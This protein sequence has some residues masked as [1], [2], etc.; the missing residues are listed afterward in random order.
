MRTLRALCL[1]G[2]SG[3]SRVLT[4]WFLLVLL[5]ALI[6]GALIHATP[7]DSA[8]RATLGAGLPAKIKSRKNIARWDQIDAVLNQQVLPRARLSPVAGPAAGL[9]SQ[10]GSADSGQPAA[11][12]ILFADLFEIPPGDFFPLTNSVLK[13]VPDGSLDGI[14]VFDKSGQLLGTFAGRSRYE[15]SGDLYK[16]RS[17]VLY[18]FEFEVSGGEFRSAGN[19]NLLDNFLVRWSD[20]RSRKA[21]DLGNLPPK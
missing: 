17:Y 1:H 11:S 8:G 12:P 2:E 5:G 18:T 4:G 14:S 3:F 19:D 7:Q 20:V 15:K 21:L 9:Q 16:S 13:L 10:G 6:H